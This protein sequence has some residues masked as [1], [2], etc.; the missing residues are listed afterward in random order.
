MR[1][2]WHGWCACPK[3]IKSRYR[4]SDMY[5]N[6]IFRQIYRTKTLAEAI[7][8]KGHVVKAKIILERNDAK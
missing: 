1:R 6:A 4:G 7:W 8:G 3:Y 5:I 2:V